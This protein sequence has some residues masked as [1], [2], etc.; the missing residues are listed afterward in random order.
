MHGR[1]MQKLFASGCTS[2]CIETC[3]QVRLTG[4]ATDMINTLHAGC[5]KFAHWRWKTL[6]TVTS[7]LCRMEAAVCTACTG[8]RPS[9][10]GTRDS[11][12]ATIFLFAVRSQT[13]WFRCHALHKLAKPVSEFS[14]WLGACSCHEAECM[15]KAECACPWKGCR[16]SELSAR[17]NVFM[18]S[19]LKVRSTLVPVVDADTQPALTRTL[20]VAQLK[21]GWVE[22]AAVLYLAG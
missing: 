2:S 4:E 6:Q 8:L 3:L 5:E 1:G 12:H 18:N 10:L 11:A 19:V 13:F 21:F 16:A 22:G 7:D 15:S 14:S 17:V 20:A 9:D